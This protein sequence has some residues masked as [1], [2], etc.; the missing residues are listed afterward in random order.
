MIF[1]QLMNDKNK[2]LT[3]NQNPETA[4]GLWATES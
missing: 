4:E 3:A 2:K 1:F